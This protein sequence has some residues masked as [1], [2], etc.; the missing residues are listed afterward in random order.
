MAAQLWP[1]EGPLG[2]RLRLGFADST[3]PWITVVG[4]VGRIKQDALDTESRIAIYLHTRSIRC[5]G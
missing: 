3:G 5:A 2:K 1:N 4:V